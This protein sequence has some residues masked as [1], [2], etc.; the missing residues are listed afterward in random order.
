MGNATITN[1]TRRP[2]IKTEMNIGV[3]YDTSAEKVKRALEI[4]NQVFRQHPMT[5]DVVV[6]FNKFA[7][8][9]LNLNV[10]H[11]CKTTDYKAYV[12]GM[13][14]MNLLIKQ[15]FDAEKIEFAF[16]TQTLYVR[17]D[18]DGTGGAGQS[19]TPCQNERSP[20]RRRPGKNDRLAA[21][22]LAFQRSVLY[23]VRPFSNFSR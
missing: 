15:Q 21:A 8:S 14:E 6:G 13:Q 23:Q 7:D 12:E 10:V 19:L 5:H 9:A 17:Q 16:P 2:H 20:I 1:V 11:W 4:L 3:T 22:R 18:G